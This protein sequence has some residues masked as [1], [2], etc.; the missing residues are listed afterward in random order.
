MSFESSQEEGQV[1]AKKS[2]RG[3]LRKIQK[4]H[5]TTWGGVVKDTA[6]LDKISVTHTMPDVTQ[7]TRIIGVYRIPE[8]DVSPIDDK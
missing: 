8:A 1:G 7:N 5:P 2:T 3:A 4:G 6:K